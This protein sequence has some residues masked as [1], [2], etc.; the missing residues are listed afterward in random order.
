[1]SLQRHFMIM[2]CIIP[3][4]HSQHDMPLWECK[5]CSFACLVL[6][7][8]LHCA[9][10]CGDA[11]DTSAG[12]FGFVPLPMCTI[13]C[14]VCKALLMWSCMAGGQGE[15]VGLVCKPA[16]GQIT[17]GWDYTLP[18]MP[19]LKPAHQPLWQSC[20]LVS[21]LDKYGIHRTLGSI[22]L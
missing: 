3:C 2:C 12:R 20:A 15:G 1:M 16:D 7:D 21:S 13:L 14:I 11:M 4:L 8:G 19:L 6:L 22:G 18:G 5:G 9:C 17:Q 10:C